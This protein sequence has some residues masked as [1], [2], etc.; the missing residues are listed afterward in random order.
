MTATASDAK[1][2]ARRAAEGG[3]GDQF[4]DRI[5]ERIGARA[6]V[7]AVFGE[8]VERG[9]VTVIPV[10]RVRWGFGGGAGSSD[11]DG[12]ATGSGAGGGGGVAADAVGYIE[13]G[14]AGATFQP[15]PPPYPSPVFLLAMGVTAALVL[16]SIARLVRG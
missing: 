9:D 11:D 8:P 7:T 16:R 6:A 2:E 15:I 4:M 13:I 1:E 10:A 12:G 3:L 5:A 14:P